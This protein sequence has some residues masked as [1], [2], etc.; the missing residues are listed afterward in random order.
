MSKAGKPYTVTE[1]TYQGDP[2]PGYPPKKPTTRNIFSN[3][4]QHPVIA[5]LQ[6]GDRIN[7][8]FLQDLH[9][10]LDTVTKIT[11]GAPAPQ[12]TAAPRPA[13]AQQASDKDEAIAKAVALKAAVE[14][15]CAMMTSGYGKMKKTMETELYADEIIALSK[16]FESYLTGKAPAAPTQER[17]DEL[18]VEDFEQEPF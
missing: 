6:A 1:F 11:G 9:K 17:L 3:A 18:D 16:Q 14:T 8:T 7:M 15:A 12:T 10:S 4:P 5:Q 2:V 13:F